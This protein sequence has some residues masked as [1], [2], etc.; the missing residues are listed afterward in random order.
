M[1]NLRKKLI[2]VTTRGEFKLLNTESLLGWLA[3]PVRPLA[4]EDAGAIG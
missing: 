3:D 1:K 4:D 2:F